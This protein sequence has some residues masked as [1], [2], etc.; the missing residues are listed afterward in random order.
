MLP[1]SSSFP[2]ICLNHVEAKSPREIFSFPTFAWLE[3]EKV[4]SVLIKDVLGPR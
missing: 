2:S 4:V 1:H 3:M